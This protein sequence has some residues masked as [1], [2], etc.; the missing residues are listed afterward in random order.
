M[1]NAYLKQNALVGGGGG[2]NNTVLATFW[3]V[4]NKTSYAIPTAK[5]ITS[6]DPD[7]FTFADGIFTAVQ[8][9]TVNIK[10]IGKGNRGS[11]SGAVITC[12]IGIYKNSNTVITKAFTEVGDTFSIESVSLNTNDTIYVMVY[13]S[14]GAYTSI[15]FCIEV[16]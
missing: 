14:A 3:A 11:S 5:R 13:N 1:A 15:G 6:C 12:N 10:G 8:N 9:C 16:V 4:Y 2:G 7:Y